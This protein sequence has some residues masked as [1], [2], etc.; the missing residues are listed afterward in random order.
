MYEPAMGM[1]WLELLKEIA[2]P[3]H[4]FTRRRQRIYTL[5]VLGALEMSDDYGRGSCGAEE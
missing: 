3:P 2:P 1:K 5:G 4:T